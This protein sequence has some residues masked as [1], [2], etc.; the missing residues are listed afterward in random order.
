MARKGTKQV[1]KG[2]GAAGRRLWRVVCDGFELEGH[3]FETLMQACEA[4]DR[5]EGCRAKIEDEGLTVRD[6]FGALKPHPLLAAERDA[7]SSFIRCLHELGLDV[8]P[9]GAIGRPSG[10]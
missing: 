8:I 7:R 6:R 3:S 2:L 5:A 10:R 9:P 1:P 4:L